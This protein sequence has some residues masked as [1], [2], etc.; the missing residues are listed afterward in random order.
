MAIISLDL[1]SFLWFLLFM[2][3]LIGFYNMYKKI[4]RY[5]IS[6][7][8]GKTVSPDG[9]TAFGLGKNWSDTGYA[10]RDFCKYCNEETNFHLYLQYEYFKVLVIFGCIIRREYLLACQA[11]GKGF[12]IDL[13]K[14]KELSDNYDPFTFLDK[15]GLA[16]IG[17][18][19]I[20]GIIMCLL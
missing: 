5:N 9:G 1:E 14:G 11:C 10:I 17:L 4:Q 18:I 6:E 3:A 20:Y 12:L 8:H 13:E 7:M 15:Y 19:F 16:I 2:I